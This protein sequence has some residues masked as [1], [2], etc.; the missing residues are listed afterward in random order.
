MPSL[1]AA[2]G[3]RRGAARSRRLCLVGVLLVWSMLMELS[4]MADFAQATFSGDNGRI[5]FTSDRDGDPFQIYSMNVDGSDQTRL[6]TDPSA[7][8]NPAYSP[9]GNRIAFA[10]SRHSGTLDIFAM[11]ADGTGQT[12]LRSNPGTDEYPAFSPDG[13]KLA[14]ASDMGNYHPRDFG[15]FMVDADGTHQTRLTPYPGF[16]RHPDFSPD[17]TKIAFDGN[18]QDNF[19]VYTMKP[20]GTGR[21][22]LTNSPAVE[23]EP[24]FSPDGAKIAFWSGRDGDIEI[25]VMNADGTGEVRLTHSLGPDLDAAFSPD[26]SKIVFRSNRDGNP[27]IYV[28]N[29]DGSNQI[30]L[31][32]DPRTDFEPTWQSIPRPP[33]PPPPAPPPSPPP[34]T[35]PP[36]PE[37]ARA[38]V[39]GLKNCATTVTV[40]K[41]GTVKLCDA[42]NPP[43]ATTTQLLTGRL[44]TRLGAHMAT[45]K[46]RIPR[47][48]RT[49]G[50]GRTTIPAAQTRPVVVKLT[51]KA[52]KALAKKGSLKVQSVIDAHGTHGQTTTIKRT[53]ALKATKRK[54][55]RR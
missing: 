46:R 51:A 37:S 17:G 54:P 11:N 7:N 27:E 40:S 55:K 2:R 34:A 19:D 15:L 49:L 32:T 1:V 36:T 22:R 45:E 39:E 9:D 23:Y 20:D 5:A 31:T 21:V 29:A 44:P 24:A 4:V 28:M 16:D 47:N 12:A 38:P 10:S 6:T 3:P 41:D 14:F 53:V 35:S 8:L 43:T 52:K 50:K 33:A 30:R 26:G 42:T 48:P 13:A 18:Y 25:Y